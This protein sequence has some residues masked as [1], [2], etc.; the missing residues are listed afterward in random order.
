MHCACQRTAVALR[1]PRQV[2]IGKSHNCS[3][4]CN[5]IAEDLT[6]IIILTKYVVFSDLTRYLSINI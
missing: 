6:I 3:L 2:A 5:Y 1:V 4:G